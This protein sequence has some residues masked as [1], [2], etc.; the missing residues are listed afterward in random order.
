MSTCPLT[1]GIF[2]IGNL[3]HRM[4]MGLQALWQVRGQTAGVWGAVR[5]CGT[6]IHGRI[7]RLGICDVQGEV[8]G[9]LIQKNYQSFIMLSSHIWMNVNNELRMLSR[10]LLIPKEVVRGSVYICAV[11][12]SYGS[13]LDSQ[14]GRTLLHL[15]ALAQT[16]SE[17]W[18]EWR[19]VVSHHFPEISFSPVNREKLNEI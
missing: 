6:E 15:L 16:Y 14:R 5:I 19:T 17:R 3:W 10:S 9:F 13:L 4:W 12:D 7:F 18:R 2:S 8:F 11:D 1:T